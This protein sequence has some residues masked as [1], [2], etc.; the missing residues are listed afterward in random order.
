[1]NPYVAPQGGMYAGSAVQDRY[2]HQ[3]ETAATQRTLSGSSEGGVQL[4][5]MVSALTLNEDSSQD[6]PTDTKKSGKK[7]RSAKGRAARKPKKK[8]KG[9]NANLNPSAPVEVPTTPAANNKKNNQGSNTDLNSPTSVATPVEAPTAPAADKMKRHR[10]AKVERPI[11]VPTQIYINRASFGI[12]GGNRPQHLLVILDLNGT[13]VFRPHPRTKSAQ[14][15]KRPFVDKFLEYIFTNFS[16]MVWSSARPANVSKMVSKVLD[17]DQEKKLVAQWNRKQ[18]DLTP[19]E[20]DMNVQVFK[21]LSWVWDDRRIQRRHPGFG[22]GERW[23]Q[24]NTVLIDDTQLKAAAEPYNLVQ[25][26]E[27]EGTAEQMKSD[28]LREVAGYLNVAS[29]S[30]DVSAYIKER[31]FRADGTW[32][33]DWTGPAEGGIGIEH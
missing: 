6:Q 8:N 17:K 31:P 24:H 33:M 22:H 20:Y 32:N 7:T 26:P 27:F 23:G 5:D 12:I 28:I 11:P 14:I 4:N 10:D 9:G 16:V 1:M 2:A 30:V 15:V 13:L 29:W 18:F 19:L 3:P 21:Q 25:I